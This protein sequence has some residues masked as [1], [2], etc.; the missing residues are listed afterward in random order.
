MDPFACRKKADF[1]SSDMRIWRGIVNVAP[2]MQ[3]KKRREGLAFAPAKRPEMRWEARFWADLRD[4]GGRDLNEGR[5]R[6]GEEGEGGQNEGGGQGDRGA[7]C[8]HVGLSRGA[9]A[10]M[11]YV[12]HRPLE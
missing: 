4:H 3:T 12:Y 10:S 6:G 7:G 2:L 9:R 1:T 8:G 11:D 5:G